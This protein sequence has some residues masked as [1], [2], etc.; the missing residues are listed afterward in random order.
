MSKFNNANSFQTVVELL[1]EEIKTFRNEHKEEYRH[2]EQAINNQS[3]M[4][5]GHSEQLVKLVQIVHGDG[6]QGLVERIDLIEKT[7]KE[8]AEKF[9]AIE[10]REKIR[11]AI[12]GAIC[13]LCSSIGGIITYVISI[14]TSMQK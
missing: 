11:A 8:F 6:N 4:L 14:Y 1:Y 7:Q 9:T 3:T 13:A 12:L 10:T 5:T 2:L